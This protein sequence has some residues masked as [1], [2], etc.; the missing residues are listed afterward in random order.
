[1]GKSETGIWKL[2][3]KLTYRRI[4][5][6]KTS[7]RENSVSRFCQ[8]DK[9]SETGLPGQWKLIYFHVS[10]VKIKPCE[11]YPTINCSVRFYVQV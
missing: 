3:Q 9:C 11:K 5:R 2:R 6:M 4:A 10:T 8:H 7:E 1:M